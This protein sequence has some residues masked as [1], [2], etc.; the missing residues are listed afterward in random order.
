ME[1]NGNYKIISH[2]LIL[3]KNRNHILL[4][5]ENNLKGNTLKCK[6]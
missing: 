1:K 6:Q 5:V 4:C 2:D 3:G